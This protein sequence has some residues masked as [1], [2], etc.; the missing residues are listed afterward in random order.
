MESQNELKEGENFC[1]TENLVI[2]VCGFDT[3]GDPFCT[4]SGYLINSEYK[5]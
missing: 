1:R 2:I 3:S 4:S 5:E